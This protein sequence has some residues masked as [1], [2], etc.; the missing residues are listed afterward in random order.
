MSIVS[1]M[2][3]GAIT[4]ADQQRL[5]DA[6][7]GKSAADAEIRAAVLEAV[8]HGA[9]VRELAAF[10]GLSTNTVSRWKRGE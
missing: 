2:A 9:S 8:E 6:I 5:L 3:R 1:P 4:P 10:T 7:A